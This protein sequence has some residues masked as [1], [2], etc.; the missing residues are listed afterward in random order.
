MS[1]TPKEIAE[2]LLAEGEKTLVFFRGIADE[3]WGRQ[4]YAEGAAWNVRQVFTH[5]TAAEKDIPLLIE[6]IVNGEEGIAEDFDLDR[7]NEGR[8]RKLGE[9]NEKELF[10][11]FWARRKKVAAQIEGYSEADLEKSGRHPFL[12]YAPVAGMV[13]LMHIHVAL[14]IRDIKK[15]LGD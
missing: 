5:V 1:K 15:A 12:G 3:D 13:R 2:K 14:H 7:Y 10:E 9:V 8:I 11:V 6:N 4:V